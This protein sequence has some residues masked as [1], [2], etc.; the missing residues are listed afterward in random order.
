V[1]FGVARDVLVSYV[2]TGYKWVA[3]KEHSLH[4]NYRI[5]MVLPSA[6]AAATAATSQ[7]LHLA[8]SIMCPTTAKSQL[9]PLL[10]KLAQRLTE[11]SEQHLL[12]SRVPR[13]PRKHDFPVPS[14]SVEAALKSI[15]E[16]LSSSS[17]SSASSSTFQS[18]TAT[19]TTT[20]R[21]STRSTTTPASSSSKSPPPPL[22]SAN[23]TYGETPPETIRDMIATLIDRHNLKQSHFSGDFVDVGSG[24]GSVVLSAALTERFHGTYRGVEYDPIRQGTSL[25][26]KVA[27]QDHYNTSR[28]TTTT[29]TAA[30]RNGI[31]KTTP[32]SVEFFCD[33][34]R[35]IVPSF[36]D[37]ASVVF[38]NCVVWD[39]DLCGAMGQLLDDANLPPNALVVS[40]SRRFPSPTFN[41]VDI[42]TLPANSGGDFTFYVSQKVSNGSST[43]A[44]NKSNSSNGTATSTKG[45]GGSLAISDAPLIMILLQEEDE[46]VKNDGGLLVE[47]LIDSSLN[48]DQVGT[49][50]M[51][52][53]TALASS[54]SGTRI[55]L[56]NKN[57]LP[58]IATQLGWWDED[59][60]RTTNLAR[61]ANASM[62]LRA[63]S[64]FPI[65]RREIAKSDI[66]VQA[67]LESLYRGAKNN[68]NESE[69]PA[70]V[71]ATP[72]RDHPLIRANVLDILGQ[73]LY[74]PIGNKVLE[75]RGVD[76]LL[77]K[78]QVDASLAAGSN[79]SGGEFEVLEA[80]QAAQA[81]RQW[82]QSCSSEQ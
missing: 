78:V 11:S 12:I 76:A 20:T 72:Q 56:Q 4:K 62:F 35:T 9:A 31:T 57:L 48:C 14:M 68:C 16:E 75:E 74:D 29:T 39:A 67:L 24:N 25:L 8:K 17:A 44:N 19:P 2:G 79:T 55:L 18:S 32:Q 82:W 41:L 77:N 22:S 60:P 69:A 52:F 51:T 28:S 49:S 63:I 13:V 26:L 3:T 42:L 50:G 80:G 10:F 37:G 21:N 5:I 59:K 64:E 47:A 70:H 27:Y 38:A 53:L 36:L 66:V 54:E 40:M 61:R 30:T 58:E 15:E 34:I 43:T 1:L 23:S 81:M 45:G 33:D 71:T 65:G 7:I 46:K 73:V 6:T